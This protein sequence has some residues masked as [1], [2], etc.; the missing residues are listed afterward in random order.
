M[1][2]YNCKICFVNFEAQRAAKYCSSNCFRLGVNKYNNN[3]KKKERRKKCPV[4][5]MNCKRCSLLITVKSASYMYCQNSCKKI[6]MKEQRAATK[7]K[8][9]SEIKKSNANYYIRRKQHI[10]I[11]N[12]KYTLKNPDSAKFRAFRFRFNNKDKCNIHSANRKAAKLNA[13]LHKLDL[14]DEMLGIYSFKVKVENITDIM[15]NVDHI[16]PLQN[17]EVCG[18]YVPWNLQ[19]LTATDNMIKSNKFDGTYD[20]TGWKKDRDLHYKLLEE[21]EQK[22]TAPINNDGAN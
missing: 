8:Y 7:E 14:K 13:L 15:H 17:K 12:K 11:R 4:Y 16:I 18:L 6:I 10:T 1:K 9:K 5:F 21:I 20:N 22:E 19:I 3:W 2:V